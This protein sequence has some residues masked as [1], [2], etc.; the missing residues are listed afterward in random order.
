ML[1]QKV[2][3]TSSCSWVCRFPFKVSV[4]FRQYSQHSQKKGIPIIDIT[5]KPQTSTAPLPSDFVSPISPKND[6][7]N[8]FQIYNVDRK[9]ISQ[10]LTVFGGVQLVMWTS[11]A[12]SAFRDLIIHGEPAPL[13]WRIS[14]SAALLSLGFLFLSFARAYRMKHVAKLYAV[15]GSST[16][17]ICT[18][19]W[20]GD[21]TTRNVTTKSI[22][23]YFESPTYYG[24]KVK[25]DWFHFLV[26]RSGDCNSKALEILLRGQPVGMDVL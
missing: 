7:P 14:A 20:N 9:R 4:T 15:P 24:F 21:L 18:Y 22:L 25:G 1:L 19:T 26:D 12:D 16:F 13:M 8:E 23:K 3:Q 11:V 2:F 10:L 5:R 6:L 17:R